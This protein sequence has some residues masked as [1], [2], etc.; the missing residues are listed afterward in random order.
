MDWWFNH[1]KTTCNWNA[2][3]LYWT[4]YTML[5]VLFVLPHLYVTANQNKV[6]VYI[7]TLSIIAQRALIKAFTWS[8]FP[9]AWLYTAYHDSMMHDDVFKWKHFPRYWPS[10]RGI[11]RS[12]GIPR[13]KASDAE[14]W[15]FLW[16]APE[17]TVEQTM[18][19]LVIWD[20][21]APIMTSL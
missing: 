19:R 7:L 13:T 11:H 3:I 12:P 15:C 10:V 14:L 16:S 21:I 5:P 6:Y 4:Y 8:L 1:N 2:C 9:S 20:A 17:S 18:V